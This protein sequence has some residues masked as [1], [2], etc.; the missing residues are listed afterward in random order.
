MKSRTR[1]NVHHQRTRTEESP[2]K[3]DLNQYTP[4]KRLEGIK[5]D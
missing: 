2:P 4:S 5:N 3:K 1:D